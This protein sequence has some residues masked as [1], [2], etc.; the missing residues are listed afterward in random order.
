MLISGCSSSDGS[1]KPEAGRKTQGN[2]DSQAMDHRHTQDKQSQ[3]TQEE[4]KG[5]KH[6]E[7]QTERMGGKAKTME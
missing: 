6:H 2:S 7:K 5:E 4:T 1:R 3:E